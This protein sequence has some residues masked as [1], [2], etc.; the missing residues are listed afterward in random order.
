MTLYTLLRLTKLESPQRRPCESADTRLLEEVAALCHCLPE[1][2]ED[3]YACT[4]LQE[5]MMALTLQDST[6][7]TVD[8]EYQLP[9]DVD[10]KRLRT[11]WEQTAEANPILRTRIVSTASHGCMQAIIRGTPPWTEYSTEDENDALGLMDSHLSWKAGQPLA[12]FSLFHAR[13]VLKIVI[14]HS[15]CDDWSMALLLREAENAY[16]GQT[17]A[18]RLFRPLVDYVQETRPQAEEFWRDKFQDAE[19]TPMSTYPPLPTVGYTPHPGHCVERSWDIN[20]Q[21]TGAFTVNTKMRLAWAILQSFYVGSTNVLFGAINVGRGVPVK[22]VEEISGPALAS[23][24]VRAQLR[25]QDTVTEALAEMQRDW[26]SGMPY[27]HVGLQNLLHLGLGPKAACGFQ[28]LLAVEPRSGH[29]VPRLFAQHRAVQRNYDLYG[30]ILRCR[31]SSAH[32]QVQ[33]WFDPAVVEPRQIERILGQLACIYDQIERLPGISLAEVSSLSPEDNEELSCLNT[34]AAPTEPALSCLHTLIEEKARSQG[35]ALAINS[36]DGDLSYQDL[37]IMASSLAAHLS[38]DLVRPGTFVPVLLQKSKWTPISMLAVMKAGGAFVLLDPSYPAPR[39]QK[40]CETVQAPVLLTC[41]ELLAKTPA[42]GVAPMLLVDDFDYE[43]TRSAGQSSISLPQ[44]NPRTPLY[45]TF[46]SGSTGTP[47]GVVVRHE[48][49]V[50]S[51]L[52]HGPPYNFQSTTRV[53]QFA[54]PAFDSCIIEHLTPL[55][56]GGCV[57]IPTQAECHSCLAQAVSQ[58]RVNVACLT[59]SVARILSPE[60]VPT[61]HTLAF[62]GE[63]VRGSDIARWAPHLQVRNAYGPAECSAV[64]SVQPRLLQEDPANI[65]FPT[66]GVGWV[67]DPSNH[68]TLMPLGCTGELLIEGPIVGAGYIGNPTQTARAFVDAPRWRK[69]FGR[70][71]YAPLYKTGDLVQCVGDGSFRYIGRKDTQVKLHGQRLELGDIEH[72]L[73]Q[74]FPE[75]KQV[76]VEMLRSGSDSPGEKNRPDAMLVGF[77]AGDSNTDEGSMFS[78]PTDEF[79][80]ACAKA[81]SRLFDI[82]PAFMVPA[83]LLPVFKIPLTSSGKLD[84]RSLCDAASMLSWEEM[85]KYR[86]EST[87]T[88]AQE[89]STS[90]EHRIRE[91]WA[92]VLNRP[93]HDI[94][95]TDS[96]FR[97]GGDSISAMQAAAGCQAAGWAITVADIFRYPS[98]QKISQKIQELGGR[99]SFASDTQED[100]TDTPFELSPVQLLFFEHV[101]EGHH[102]FTQQFLLRL[103]RTVSANNGQWEQFITPDA[104]QSIVFREHW[105]PSGDDYQPALRQIMGE[106]QGALDIEKGPLL[107]VDLIH[108]ETG[109]DL[110]G[111]IAHHLDLEEILT[112]GRTTQAPSLSFQQWCRMQ[113]EYALK[114]IDLQ[115]ALPGAIPAPPLHYWGHAVE[116]NTWGQAT[117]E[118]ICL[119]QETTQALLGPV[120]D[121]FNTDVV[122]ILQAA[123]LHSFTNIFHDSPSPTVFS[124]A[125]GREPW[126]PHI[127]ISRTVGWFTTIAPLFIDTRAGQDITEVLRRTKDGRRA[128]PGNGWPYFVTRYCHPDGKK[129]CPGHVPMEI[130]FNYT[131]L[132]QQLE[133]SAALLELATAPDHDLVPIPPDLPRFALID[134]SATVLGGSRNITFFY[135]SQMTHQ[136]QLREWPRRFQRTLE[137]IPPVLSQQ[138]R[139][140]TDQQLQDL[141]QAASQ[142]CCVE[143]PEIESIYP[144]APIQL[145]MWLSQLKVADMYWSRIRWTVV[146]SGGASPPVEVEQVRNAWQKVVD[147]HPILRT[148]FLNDMVKSVAADL[149]LQAHHDGTVSCL[150]TIHHTLMDGVTGQIMLSDFRDAYNGVLDETP[151]TLYSSYVEYLLDNRQSQSVGYWTEYLDGIRPCTLSSADLNFGS[152]SS[153]RQFCHNY[154]ITVSSVLR[155][156][157]GLLLRA[158]T[159]SEAVCF[160]YLTSGR[161][162]P[163]HGAST[164]AGP[165]INLLICRLSFASDASIMSLLQDDQLSHGRSIENQHWSMAEVLRSLG[166]SGQPLF[167]TAM[168][169]QNQHSLKDSENGSGAVRLIPEGGHDSTEYDITVNITLGEDTIHGNL[170]YW[171]QSLGDEQGELIADTFQ[172]AVLQLVSAE[173]KHP[174]DLDILGPKKP[175]STCIH[176]IISDQSVARPEATAISAW[177][178][179][180]AYGDLERFA[181]S[182][183]NN[184]RTEHGAHPGSFIPICGVLKAGGAFILLDTSHPAERLRDMIQQNFESASVCP[185][186][187]LIEHLN[188]TSNPDTV[189]DTAHASVGSPGSA[190]YVIFTSGTTGKPKASVIEHES[191]CSSAVAH[192]RA[193]H[194]NERSRILQFASFAFDASIVEILTTL[195]TG[196]C[197]CVPSQDEKERRLAEAIQRY[198]V[199]WTLLTPSVARTLAPKNLPTLETL[200]LG[201]EAMTDSDVQRW[202]PHVKLMNAYGPSECSVIATTQSSTEELLV[203]TANIGK[204]TGC[205]TWVVDPSNSNSPVPIGAPGEL[206]LQ[207]P[208]VGRG[209]VNHPEQQRASFLSCPAWIRHIVPDLGAKKLYKTGDLVRYLPDGSLQ[210]LGRKDRQVKLHGQRI[211]LSEVEQHVLRCFPGDCHEVFATL[212]TVERTGSDYL[213]A[214]VVQESPDK[215]E[216]NSSF[217]AAVEETKRR[218][219]AEVPAMLVPAA[220][221]PLRELPRLVNGKLNRDLI[222]QQAAQA[223]ELHLE[224][225]QEARKTWRPEDL[226]TGE[227][228]L[229]ALWAEVLNSPIDKVGPCDNFFQLGGDSIAA[230]KLASAACHAGF[231]L[232]VP[233]IFISPQLRDL[234]QIISK[235]CSTTKTDPVQSDITPLSLIPPLQCGITED[236]I[237]DIMP[238]ERPAA[239]D[240]D[241]DKLKSAWEHIAIDNAILRTRI[242]ETSGLGCLQVVEEAE[243]ISQGLPFGKSLRVDLMLSMHHAVYDAWSLPLLLLR[244]ALSQ[245]DAALEY[246]QG[247]FTDID[248]EP[249]PTLPSPSFRPRAIQYSVTRSTAIRLAWALVQ[250]QYQGKHDIVFGTVSTGRTAPVKGIEAMSGPTIAT[251][252][253]RVKIDPKMSV[254]TQMVPFEQ[255]GLQTIAALGTN[256]SRRG[257]VER[258]VANLDIMEPLNTTFADGAFNTYALHLTASLQPGSLSIEAS[259]DDAVVPDWQMERVLNQFAFLLERIYTRPHATLQETMGVNLGDTQQLQAWNSIDQ[260]CTTQP[261]A[262]AELDYW[263][264]VGQEMFVPIYLDRSRW[265]AVAALA[266]LKVGAAFVLLDTSYPLGRL[267][268]ICDEIRAPV[269]ITSE[270][271]QQV[272]RTLIDRLVVVGHKPASEP[273]H[274][275][276]RRH[277][278][279]RKPKGAIV[280]NGAF[281]TMAVPYAR[282]MEI[283]THSRVLHFASYAFDVSIL[284]IFGTLFA[285]ACGL[286]NAVKNFQPSHTILTPS[287]LR[288]ITPSDLVP[289]R[290]VALIDHVRLLNTYGP[291]ECTV[292]YTMQPSVRVPSRSANIGHPIAGA[293][294]VADPQDPNRPVPIGAVG[295]LLLQGPLTAA[296]F[297]S[298]PPWLAS[299]ASHDHQGDPKIYRTGDLVKDYQVKLRGQRF[300]LGEVEDHVQRAFEGGLKD[301]VA[302][303]DAESARQPSPSPI[304]PLPAQRYLEDGLP[305]YM[306]PNAVIPLLQM[307][308]TEAAAS[309]PRQRVELFTLK[310]RTL[311]RIWARS[312]GL[313]L[314]EI[315]DSISALQ[316]TTQARSVGMDHSVADLFHWRTIA[317]QGI[318]RSDVEKVLPCTPAQRGI[319]LSQMRDNTSYAPHFIWK[320]QQEDTRST[321]VDLDRLVTAWHQVVARHPALRTAF[322]HDLSNDGHF[323]QLILR[324]IRPRVNLIQNVPATDLEDGAIPT[325]LTRLSAT[326]GQ[327]DGETS[328]HQ[329]TICSTDTGDVYMRLD[330][331]HVIIDAMSMA[332]LESDFCQAYDSSLPTAPQSQAYEDYVA[333]SQKQ[334][335]GPAYSYWQNYLEGVEPCR[336]PLE[337]CQPEDQATDALSQL[338][339]LLVNSGAEIDSFCRGTDW[340]ASSLLYFAWALTLSAFTRSDDVCFGTLTSGR[341]VPVD[342]IDGAIGQFSNM[343]VCRVRTARDLALDEAALCLQEDFSNVLSYQAFPLIEIARAAGV[344]MEELTST[345]INVQYEPVSMHEEKQSLSLTPVSGKDPISQDITVY[346]LLQRNGC[347]R[348]TMSYHSS[349]VP[350]AVATQVSEYFN[351]AV[352]SLLEGPGKYVRDLELLTPRDQDRLLCWN[353]PLP[354]PAESTVHDLIEANAKELPDHAAVVGSDGNFTYKEISQLGTRIAA[355]LTARGV[356]RG[357]CVPL[358]FE[359]SRWVPVA[360]LSVLKAGGTV[361]PLDPTQPLA[362]LKAVCERVKATLVLSS[363]CQASISRD[364]VNDVLEIGNVTL[365]DHRADIESEAAPLQ[366]ALQVAL[367]PSQPVY[368]LFTSGSTGAPKGVMVS[369]SSYCYAAENHIRAFGL[370]RT[371]RVLQI[372]SYSFDVSMMEILTTLIAGATICTLTEDERS[373]MLMTGACPIPVSHAYLTPSLASA[374][375][376]N[377][378]HSWIK[379]LVLQ[380]EP[381][382]AAHITTW[383]DKCQLINAYG[384][385]ECAVINT[386]TSALNAGDDARCIGRGIGAHCWVVDPNDENTLL[387]IGAVGELLLGGPPVGQGYLSEPEKTHEAFIKPPSWLRALHRDGEYH[388]R[389][390]KTGDLVRYDIQMGN[391]LFEGRKDYQIKVHGQRVELAEVERHTQQCFEGAKEVVVHQVLLPRP[392]HSTTDSSCPASSMAPRLVACVAGK[393]QGSDCPMSTTV[394]NS[395]K[396]S[397]SVLLAPSTDFHGRAAAALKELRKLL[398]GYMIPDIIVPI[399]R[400]PLSS[401]GKTDRSRLR[402]DLRAVSPMDWSAYF[403]SQQ[404]TRLVEGK[405]EK[406]FHEIISAVLGIPPDT[407]CIDDSLYHLGG[408]SIDAVKIAAKARAAGFTITSHDILRHPTIREWAGIA[409]VAE[410]R[411]KQVSPRLYEPFSLVTDNE[412]QLVLSS[413]FHGRNYPYTVDNVADIIPTVDFQS[414]YIDNSSLVS[415]AE[416]FPAPMDMDRLYR[417]CSKV[418]LH[419]SILRT[420]FVGTDERMLQVILHRADPMFDYV[421]CDDPRTYISE[422]SQERIEPTT[423]HGQMLVSFTVVTSKAHP[424]WAFLV[425]LSHAQYDGSSLPF[426]WQAI[427]AAYEDR[428]LQPT[429]QFR[430]VV[431]NR[432]GDDHSKPLSFW[433]TY[434]QNASKESAD[435]LGVTSIARGPRSDDTFTPLTVRREVDHHPRLPDITLAT[436]VKASIAW[437]L[438]KHTNAL[439]EIVLGQ[440]VHGRGSPL[441]GMET[442]F[443]PCINFLPIRISI[444]Q[445]HTIADLLRHVQAQQLATVP[446]DYV[447][448]KHIFSKCTSWQGD[449]RLGCIVHHQAAQPSTAGNTGSVRISGVQS[450]SST[451]WANSTPMPGQVGIISIERVNSVDLY[452]TF[453]TEKFAEPLFS[454]F[455]DYPLSVLGKRGVVFSQ[456]IDRTVCSTARDQDLSELN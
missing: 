156:A 139:L 58:Y 216:S 244:Y 213:V 150:L 289:I 415:M 25:M 138:Q 16:C 388:G 59:P 277:S 435:P 305:S 302:L 287:L 348:V 26:A 350:T 180:L 324:Y 177:D 265:I 300:E 57:C 69:R 403:S 97:L 215:A 192:S 301:V 392:A 269:I 33:A 217:Q 171:T 347:I 5:G 246:W 407:V 178:G 402:Q 186:A 245:K 248:T 364:L 70:V 251:V 304:P 404:T 191:F 222:R 258:M 102:Q 144:C 370:D 250:A 254:T 400:V 306:L 315:G 431:Y 101:P 72:H 410:Q 310:E 451:S 38:M 11:A 423:N 24:P 267:R 121:A 384:P 255:V 137:K 211:E 337:T 430:E 391:L 405:A 183:A 22:G 145:G 2:L 116:Q 323:E 34:P 61:L 51:A 330:I 320:V 235:R 427:A 96:F 187:I 56:M 373:H 32:M 134:V 131:G 158:Y 45:A 437:V 123:L 343:S 3:L 313:P 390:Y 14:H 83:V 406:T 129:R 202:L 198:E 188:Q 226:T 124:E 349:R 27:E 199:N 450:S 119:S 380:G 141:L 351:L 35:D 278:L 65:G 93:S 39:L 159:G 227:R 146:P 378:A 440:V 311:Q 63:R 434:L 234:A 355:S 442:V 453:P 44:V 106:S 356:Q 120:N 262:P 105:V 436:L 231:D 210:Y 153:L 228:L 317:Q 359:K 377:K 103:T 243:K 259:F 273:A 190:A 445:N 387:P 206:L 155:V 200:V 6:A 339:I 455:A 80:A 416:V 117:Q 212:I 236:D 64:F 67:V 443:G 438:S 122:D 266:V 113:R 224:K 333:F 149:L 291:A 358:C 285:G 346:V 299:L 399:S 381:M 162:I 376:S 294:W 172:Q 288:A 439:P 240:V 336:L 8:Y 237:E 283:D 369:H 312:L 118:T 419:Y 18:K 432:L 385:T 184:L 42:L 401:S 229:Q 332:I 89:P 48:G 68:E 110:L 163:L 114:N 281:V 148:I 166:L 374:L 398:P 413:Y 334:S 365:A 426:L 160:G 257:E 340:T 338:D 316:A 322:Q 196:G 15:I 79:R 354:S 185:K 394:D 264:R 154:G 140:T 71:Q 279:S 232:M 360:I 99:S 297:I 75:A 94:G 46:T 335:S 125:H 386:A 147:R 223:L 136:D 107:V 19:K 256:A 319:L 275:A 371:S 239:Y 309:A 49:Y 420:I 195:L 164:I 409:S 151:G 345:A 203:Q 241:L 76:V 268:A 73:H 353:A 132:F 77:I 292:V 1:D 383:S 298:C 4:P 271:R 201:G 375:D 389:L 85:Q 242:I 395:S 220:I 396:S 31:P 181:S 263:S 290:T 252:P 448:L 412:R 303:L 308:R 247:Q 341:L 218:L 221:V 272:A 209:Y 284:E 293:V 249:F 143:Q 179:Q 344:P 55:I 54:S 286:A 325:L 424:E 411:P 207:G 368:V 91:I 280:E 108:E 452:M 174:N 194:I 87:A 115:A 422:R 189:T 318:R 112:S 170:T 60:S 193:L 428:D 173:H 47:K 219:K 78:A 274:P 111:F 21:L 342:C 230:M 95:V 204:G 17:L 205:I 429:T 176:S 152:T 130:L 7:Y 9:R 321:T 421:E 414:F 157:W 142:K 433:Q 175:S 28:T 329:L 363:P 441:P 296:A 261:F 225:A 352:S 418:M 165:L 41:K 66:D 30:L 12:Y 307:P 382:S 367:S 29:Q 446:H 40:M 52:S 447:S 397:S 92:Q 135:N 36:W 182:W 168:S 82:L 327:L 444:N 74:C 128:I 253:L 133:R 88:H 456:A 167:N 23:V 126:D 326:V 270:S 90:R 127:N 109:R 161:D 43:T 98:I 50:A 276:H 361:V 295:E 449:A 104:R 100:P 208:I 328:P 425:R 233:D 379:T 81:E 13:R 62:V 86:T 357:Q 408:D 417:A 260:H 393:V 197:V 10:L 282:T 37:D 314:S 20:P 372:S 362:R 366:V 238:S 53:L 454:N 169:L 84:R 331:S 214:S